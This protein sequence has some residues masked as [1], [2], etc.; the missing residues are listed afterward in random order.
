MSAQTLT[1][2]FLLQTPTTRQAERV[3]FSLTFG[4]FHT[5]WDYF[6]RSF[7]RCLQ[8]ALYLL[9][10]VLMEAPGRQ[11]TRGRVSLG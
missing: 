6:L 5:T 1:A 11:G 4:P 3:V 2:D 10:R 8:M 9:S 7:A